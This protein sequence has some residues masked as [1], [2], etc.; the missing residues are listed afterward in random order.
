MGEGKQAKQISLPSLDLAC[1]C[2]QPDVKKMVKGKKK[3]KSMLHKNT[4]GI[5]S[6]SFMIFL[7]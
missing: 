6:A 1:V 5:I 7:D 2:V 4:P 3:K